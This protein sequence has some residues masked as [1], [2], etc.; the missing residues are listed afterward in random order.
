M[1]VRSTQRSNGTAKIFFVTD[2]GDVFTW[3]YGLLG[4]TSEPVFSPTPQKLVRLEKRVVKVDCGLDYCV[5]FTGIEM[6]L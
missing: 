5:L 1:W 2:V 6:I 3:G 4:N